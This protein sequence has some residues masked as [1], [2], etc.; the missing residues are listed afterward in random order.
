MSLTKY[1]MMFLTRVLFLYECMLNVCTQL[2][3][4]LIIGLGHF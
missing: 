1:N 3:F 4:D 2:T